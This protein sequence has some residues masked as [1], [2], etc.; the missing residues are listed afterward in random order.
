MG[1]SARK[2]NSKEKL[3]VGR[4]TVDCRHDIRFSRFAVLAFLKRK[5]RPKSKRTG[6]V[7]VCELHYQALHLW[8]QENS[9]QTAR[10]LQKRFKHVFDLDMSTSRVKVMRNRLGWTRTRR[11]Y[12]QLISGK[13]RWAMKPKVRA[14]LAIFSK[15]R[16]GIYFFYIC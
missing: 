12:G 14:E 13:N 1:K 10:V 11:K 3:P 6:P 15:L 8:I 7:K 16:S 5:T 2:K 9:E 4:L